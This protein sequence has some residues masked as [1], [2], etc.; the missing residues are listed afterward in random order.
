MDNSPGLTSATGQPSGRA[1]R[2]A[3]LWPA[4]ALIIVPFLLLIA[5]QGYE[6]LSRSPRAIRREQL[7]AHSFQVIL[8]LGSLRNAIQDAERGQGGYL[9]TGK[10]TYL[11]S[12]E[13]AIDRIPPLRAQLGRLTVGDP[14]QEAALPELD[15]TIATKLNELQRA[16]DAY[17]NVG[18]AAAERIVSQNAGLDAVPEIEAQIDRLVTHENELLRGRLVQAAEADRTVQQYALASSFLAAALMMV[19]VMLLMLAFRRNRELQQ[20]VIRRVES[21]ER[22]NQELAQ[23]NIELA[24][25]GEEAR[26]AREEA[27]RAE[28]TKGRFLA[29]ASHDL[30][31]PLQAVSLLNGAMRRKAT[32]PDLID[33]LAQQAVAVGTIGRLLNALLDI[34]K[35]EAGVIKPEP[36]DFSV[37]ALLHT[38]AR[39]FGGV[40]A[41]KGLQIEV[42]TR[43]P[44]LFAHSDPALIEQ[45][46]RNLTSNAI[47]YTRDGGVRLCATADASWVHIEVI[48]T[49]VGISAEQVQLIG[50]EFYQIGVPTNSTREGYGLGMSI[51]RRLVRLLQINL[52]IRSELGKGSTFALRVPHG[53]KS[54][55]AVESA[56][57]EQPERETRSTGP[58]RVLLVEDD[59]DVRNA[60]RL[61]LKSDGYLVVT[62]ASCAEALQ[63]ARDSAP[64]DLL[65]TDFHLGANETGTQVIARLREANGDTLKA[66]LITGDT[67]SAIKELTHDS[68]LRVLSKPVRAEE[69]LRL[70]SDLLAS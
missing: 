61:L 5:M 45:I 4:V 3:W 10:R 11:S 27:Q 54:T 44:D 12:Y 2:R 67:S 9:L 15:R 13:S 56:A 31:Q 70:A 55:T 21:S 64:I 36:G 52:E 57:P 6:A 50:E 34:S 68:N 30:R 35:L 22:I 43:S 63:K 19:G 20:E 17:N 66:I 38:M 33:A 65:V 1:A 58:A 62:A 37:P 46:L 41:A 48:D 42:Q 32:D 26:Q 25:A 53:T 60:T 16:V 14:V 23:R 8:T 59:P 24:R 47:K 51:V 28:Q 69:F 7:V 29:T 18:R 49:G 40:A 39:E